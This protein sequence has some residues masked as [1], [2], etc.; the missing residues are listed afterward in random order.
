MTVVSKFR[1]EYIVAGTFAWALA[2]LLVYFLVVL[3]YSVVVG[4]CEI[5][6]EIHPRNILPKYHNTATS[7]TILKVVSIVFLPLYFFFIWQLPKISVSE[8]EIVIKHFFTGTIKR[9]TYD[10]IAHIGGSMKSTIK[11][12]DGLKISYNSGTYANFDEIHYWV[13]KYWN[14]SRENKEIKL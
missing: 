14:K 9:I 11:L 7:I 6:T 5:L 4:S 13:M 2:L 12:K 8:D 1:V 3:I 10:E